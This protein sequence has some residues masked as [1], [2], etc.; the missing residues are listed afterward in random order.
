MM[1]RIVRVI[2]AKSERTTLIPRWK[3]WIADILGIPVQ[4]FYNVEADIKVDL[5]GFL[6]PNTVIA[7]SGIN[8]M[9]VKTGGHYVAIRS[10]QP[11]PMIM[12]NDHFS[13]QTCLLLYQVF[14]EKQESQRST[15]NLMREH[16]TAES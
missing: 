3:M 7:I 6:T 1:T 4:N 14:P 2:S 13:E 16:I 10:M 5:A 11:V 9:C 8:F 15:I 12:T